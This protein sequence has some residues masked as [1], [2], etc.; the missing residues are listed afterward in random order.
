MSVHLRRCCAAC[1]LFWLACGV[2]PGAEPVKFH[3][4]RVVPL[5]GEGQ[6][7][8][9]PNASFECGTDGWGSTEMDLLPGWYG[10]LNGLFGKLD[11][12]TASDGHTSLKIELTP[13]NQPV[14]YNDYLH[15]Q[16]IRIKAPLAASVGWITVKPGAAIRLFGG[17]EG[18]RGRHSGAAG[19]ATVPRCPGRETRATFHRLE[20][21]FARFHA[22]RRS[23]LRAGG[24][25]PAASGRQSPAARAGDRLARCGATSAKRSKRAFCHPSARRIGGRYRQAWQ[26]LRLGGTLAVPAQ[27]SLGE[28]R[29]PSRSRIA[30]DRLFR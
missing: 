10:T 25:R 9:V 18:G 11:S 23:L 13:E 27:G 4:G 17:H 7:N 3:P 2:S 28:G 20:A 19:R 1:V 14:A 5:L 22:D 21:I 8:L 15:T 12:T 29:S 16:R 30:I 26:Y 24:A 6:Q